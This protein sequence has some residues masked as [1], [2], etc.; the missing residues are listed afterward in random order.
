M[1]DWASDT[2]YPA[3]GDAWSATPIKVTPSAGVQA[4]GHTPN[5]KPPAQY[6][7]WF[8]NLV[9]RYLGWYFY[10]PSTSDNAP[11]TLWT[12]AD[13]NNRYLIDHNGYPMGRATIFDEP[14]GGFIDEA[15]TID[16]LGGRWHFVSS[17]SSGGGTMINQDPVSS[18]P[19]AFMQ[20]SNDGSISSVARMH[21]EPIVY[22]LNTGN[23]SLVLE[24][25][26]ALTNI[27]ANDTLIYMGLS[28]AAGSIAIAFRKSSAETNWRAYA[29]DGST[30]T[31][32]DTTVVPTAG[33][34][35]TQRFRLELHGSA[36]P[37]AGMKARFFINETLTN[38]LTSAL[39][40]GAYTLFFNNTA[41]GA[42]QN[43]LCVGPIRAVWN[44]Y[45]SLAEL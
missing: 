11:Q 25:E 3:G 41:S 15:A 30:T 35:P 10:P 17:G 40:S 44:R 37:Y 6:E 27:G 13:G 33:V 26:A 24:W 21:T 8:K 20:L 45:G 32:Q 39:A 16:V 34:Y 43:D 2:N 22:F 9:A 4:A 14:W 12:D 18:Y 5:T 29:F 1:P 7:N 19:S 36:S 31:N 42:T 28:D 38:T 23:F